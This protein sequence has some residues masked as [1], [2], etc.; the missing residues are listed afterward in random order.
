MPCASCVFSALSVECQLS[1]WIWKPSR[2]SLR[3]AAIS[4]MNSCGVLPAFSAAIMMGA[5]WAS[6][7]Q[8]K[9]TSLACMRWCR[10]QMSAWMYS[11]MWPMWNLPLAYGRAVVTKSLRWGMG[12][13]QGE[14]VI[15]VSAARR[16]ARAPWGYT[17]SRAGARVTAATLGATTETKLY[18]H[19]GTAAR[20][21]R[22]REGPE[23]GQGFRRQ[24][25]REERAGRRRRCLLRPRTG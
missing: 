11:M 12:V 3:P 15:L 24:Q 23:H 19:P 13:F 17:L 7:A 6:S 1:N 21:A 20:G 25:G 4:A 5:P 8:T 14:P 9:C 18:G 10:T 22:E 16:P 2:Y